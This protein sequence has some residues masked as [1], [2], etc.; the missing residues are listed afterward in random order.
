MQCH[1]ECSLILRTPNKLVAKQTDHNGGSSPESLTPY[2]VKHS[3]VKPP[4]SVQSTPC[5]CNAI[6]VNDFKCL[7]TYNRI[8]YGTH[9]LDNLTTVSQGI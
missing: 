3:V 5:T 6:N 8:E 4:S 1:R 2:F 7:S 9:S